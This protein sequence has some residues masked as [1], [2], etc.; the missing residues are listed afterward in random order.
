MIPQEE[1]NEILNAVAIKRR[2]RDLQLSPE[3]RMVRFEAMQAAS[4]RALSSNPLALAA[5]HKR[6]RLKRRQSQLKHFIAKLGS[7]LRIHD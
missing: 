1:L 5:F 4:W 7:P 6:N 3:Q 2:K